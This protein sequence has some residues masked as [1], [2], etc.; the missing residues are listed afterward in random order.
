[1]TSSVDLDLARKPLPEAPIETEAKLSDERGR[2]AR[3]PSQFPLAAWRDILWRVAGR[4]TDDRIMLI[5]AGA[6]FYMLLALFPAL[7]V[8]VSIY[9]IV[10]DPTTASQHVAFLE[11]LM[12]AG[13][14]DLISGQLQELARQSRDTAKIG[15]LIAFVTA[16]WSASNGVKTIFEALN[17]AYQEREK[18]SFLWLNILAFTFTFAAMLIGIFMIFAVGVLPAVLALVTIDERA[19]RLISLMRWPALLVMIAIG[20]SILYRFGPSREQAKWRWISWG[21]GLATI[22]WIAASAGFSFYL[23]NFADYN[24]TYGSLGAVVG[25]MF[26]IW[27]SVLILIVGAELNAEMERQTAIDTTTGAPLPM[28]ERGA[29]VADTLGEASE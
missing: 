8:F 18:R 2:D 9:G 10:A 4:V 1:M 17:I 29:V 25:L 14:M 20:I 24:A 12:P 28:G 16:Y 21:G 22:V 15:L 13:G 19:G 6:T 26:W 7:A 3:R 11:G 27:I 23:Q 5:A